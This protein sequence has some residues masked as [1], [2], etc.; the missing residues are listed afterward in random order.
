MRNLPT[1]DTDIERLFFTD[2]KQKKTTAS[3]I[4]GH[5]SR[6]GRVGS[7]VMPFDRMSGK[8]KRD[9][10]QPGPLITYSLFEDLVPFDVFDRMKYEQHVQLLPKW[11]KKYGD[12]YIRR[13]WG[14]SRFGFNIIL[15]A[16]TSR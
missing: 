2:V 12:E 13:E 7:M 15:E 16:I 5:A 6:L 4:R 9:Y 11:R 10:W 14:L 3:G 1:V 8:A